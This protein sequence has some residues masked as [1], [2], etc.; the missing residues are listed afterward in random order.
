MQR[1]DRLI[2]SGRHGRSRR[3]WGG[4]GLIVVDKAITQPW[5]A[6]GATLDPE[7][8]VTRPDALR[9]SPIASSWISS[10]ITDGFYP[11]PRPAYTQFPA[12]LSWLLAKIWGDFRPIFGPHKEEFFGRLGNAANRYSLS[13]RQETPRD[14]L[15]AVLHE[16]WVMIEEVEDENFQVMP[17][18]RG[19][20]IADDLIEDAERRGYMTTEETRLWFAE[21]G[22]E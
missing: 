15:G 20:E 4:A 14:L 3:H 16:A 5:R 7:G 8:M 21:R 6:A 19:N 1:L 10:Q 22:F 9:P 18:A 2:A 11:D 17:V 13:N 12:E